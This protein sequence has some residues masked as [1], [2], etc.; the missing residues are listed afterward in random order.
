ML[1]NWSAWTMRIAGTNFNLYHWDQQPEAILVHH[2]AAQPP[3]VPP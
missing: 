3:P 2:A 1:I